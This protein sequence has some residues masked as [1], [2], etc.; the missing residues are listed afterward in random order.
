MT[1]WILPEPRLLAASFPATGAI[2]QYNAALPV[3]LDGQGVLLQVDSNGLLKVTLG[4]GGLQALGTA[5]QG[6]PVSGNPLEVSYE[7]QSYADTVA[8]ANPVDANAD[9]VRPRSSWFGVP[10]STIVSEN[11]AG[12]LLY[13]SNSPWAAGLFGASTLAVRNDSAA[14]LLSSGNGVLSPLAVDDRGAMWTRLYVPAAGAAPFYAEDAAHASGDLG[15]QVLTRR[16]N[17][18]SASSA[19]TEGDYATLNTDDLGHLYTRPRS[20][21]SAA[22]ADRVYPIA[23]L[24]SR[25]VTTP[26][27][28]LA[29]N[30]T[31]AA[32]ATWEDL[33]PEISTDGYTRIGLWIQI[34]N[35]T[36]T[37][38]KVRCLVKH[39]A[40]DTA[41]YPLPILKADTAAAGSYGIFAE[42][43]SVDIYFS[44]ATQ[45]RMLLLTWTLDNVVPYVQF[46][47]QAT[48]AVGG[49]VRPVVNA[50]NTK[51]TYAWGQ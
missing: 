41:E 26:V 35:N 23:D 40:A 9:V 29:E 33:G 20:Y 46:Q 11:G 30:L 16:Q 49:P 4:A 48:D 21:D 5:P 22:Q 47:I 10:Y 1:T 18:L 38:V 32:S 37:K 27:Q 7:A 24:A 28:L 51:V 45:T 13:A 8:F 31:I 2:A 43:E 42:E 44:G 6:D 12:R 15:V 25:R 34:A 39:T 19:G 36:S 3:L 50:A 17:T 14:T